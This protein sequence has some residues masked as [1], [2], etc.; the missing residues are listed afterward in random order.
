MRNIFLFILILFSA[1]AYPQTIDFQFTNGT[2]A[3]HNYAD[4]KWVNSRIFGFSVF[5]IKD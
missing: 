1:V 5:C 3:S 2:R 4:V